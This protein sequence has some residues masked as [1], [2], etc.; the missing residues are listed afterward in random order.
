MVK[1]KTVTTTIEKEIAPVVVIEPEVD[2]IAIDSEKPR[3]H[4][5]QVRVTKTLPALGT[6]FNQPVGEVIYW[7]STEDITY[8]YESGYQIYMDN[9]V[10]RAIQIDK[11]TWVPRERT[12]KWVDN[13][14]N[15]ILE[16][17]YFTSEMLSMYETE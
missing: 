5:I 3:K 2:P 8:S 13:L 16:E 12:R 10:G 14:P 7:E 11:K 9:F 15:A 1:K 17:G 4:I 6:T